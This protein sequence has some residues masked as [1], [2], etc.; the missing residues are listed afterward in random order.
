MEND[1]PRV[2]VGDFTPQRRHLALKSYIWW[3]IGTLSFT[4]VV[5]FVLLTLNW[6]KI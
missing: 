5:D 3:L 6:I 4:I 1:E 2:I